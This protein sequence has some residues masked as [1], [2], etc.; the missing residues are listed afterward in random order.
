VD[1]GEEALM[2]GRRARKPV[3]VGVDGSPSAVQATRG[4]RERRKV[5]ARRCSCCTPPGYSRCRTST[6]DLC[7]DPRLHEL[8]HRRGTALVAQAAEA[9]AE[10]VSGVEIRR[11]VQPGYPIAQLAMQS[12]AAQLLVLSSRGLGGVSGLPV[13]SVAAALVA[14]AA[15]PVVVVHGRSRGGPVRDEGPVVVE[16]DGSPAGQAALAFAF[17]AADAAGAK[18]VAVHAWGDSAVDPQAVQGDRLGS[19]P[20]WGAVEQQE[21]ALLA[22]RLAGWDE[23][24]PDVR[25]ERVVSRDRAARV[26][27]EQSGRARLLVVGVHGQDSGGSALGSVSHAVLARA[28]CRVAVVGPATQEWTPRAPRTCACAW[29]TGWCCRRVRATRTRVAAWSSGSCTPM[30]PRPIGRAGSTRSTRR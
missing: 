11:Q 17:A 12:R 21:R 20:D 28:R 18:L 23:K 1:R 5:G 27:I 24:Y 14:H 16:V 26:L 2:G 4:R 8:V 25:V 22:E 9:A 13:G 10:A 30:A 3:L 15:C 7:L 19:V 6:A 29:A